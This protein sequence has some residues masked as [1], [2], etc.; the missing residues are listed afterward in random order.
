[1]I[2]VIHP[3]YGRPEQAFETSNKW[4]ER[5]DN[6]F[7]YILSL[8]NVD[9]LNYKNYEWH[10]SINILINNKPSYISQTNN[11]AKIATGDLFIVISDD[12]DCP[13][14]W[15]TLLLN[16]INGQTDFLVKT[17]DGMQDN[18]TPMPIMDR[19]YYNRFSYICEPGYEHLFVDQEMVVVAIMLGRLIKSDLLF[20]H[21][22]YST[23]ESIYDDINKKNDST[24][25]Q[26]LAH[27]NE[28]LAINFGIDNPVVKYE[29][30]IW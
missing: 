24:H 9:E 17:Q 8:V 29:D 11:A 2:T 28:R 16:E 14:H 25:W 23:G 22:H 21:N 30:I 18:I 1:M 3:S 15:D 12:I 27:F 13:E 7:E 10:S 6:K 26:G 5:A 19:V 20:K 4:I